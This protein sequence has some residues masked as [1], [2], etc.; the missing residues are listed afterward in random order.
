MQTLQV[1]LR[2]ADELFGRW[3]ELFKDVLRID[4]KV[5]TFSAGIRHSL[6]FSAFSEF[7]VMRL[8]E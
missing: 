5:V 2:R 3:V 6:A 4:T 1:R 8:G 7:N